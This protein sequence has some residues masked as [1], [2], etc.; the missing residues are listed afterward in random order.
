MEMTPEKKHGSL[1]HRWLINTASV[2]LALGLVCVAAVTLSFALYYYSNMESDLYSRAGT[3]S[4]FFANYIN[5]DYNDFYQS[6]ITYTQ[7]YEGKDKLELQFINENG[8]L[9]ETVSYQTDSLDDNFYFGTL[10]SHPFTGAAT[11]EAIVSV[12]VI[13]TL[14]AFTPAPA[15]MPSPSSALGTAV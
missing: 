11:F 14:A 7:T 13:A 15:Q 2:I 10:S 4:A 9:V 1:R 3:T 5:Q 12:A 8:K 6:C